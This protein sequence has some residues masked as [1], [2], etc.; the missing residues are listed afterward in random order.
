VA[1]PPA[2]AVDGARVFVVAPLADGRLFCGLYHA[3][4]TNGQTSTST[5]AHGVL[6]GTRV[7][8]VARG[9][10]WAV[11]HTDPDRWARL[12]EVDGVTWPDPGVEHETD[13]VSAPLLHGNRLLVKVAHDIVVSKT[14]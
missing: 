13:A 14:I 3:D 2:A 9:G 8:V 12:H 10:R 6:D 11:T 5:D 7:A 1:G 4:W